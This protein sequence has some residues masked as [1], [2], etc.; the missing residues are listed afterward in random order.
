MLD[1]SKIQESKYLFNEA[2]IGNYIKKEKKFF[3]YHL[4]K[5]NEIISY[6]YNP[7]KVFGPLIPNSE[8]LLSKKNTGLPYTWEAV[9]I[10]DNWIGI[11]TF[12]PNKLVKQMLENGLIPGETFQQEKLIK[13]LKYKPDFSNERY[14]IEVKH[15]H[16]VKDNIGYFPEK[17]TKRG[18]CQL[19]AIFQL[20]K[21]GQQVILIY[22]MQ[23]NMTDTFSISKDR[24][25]VYYNKVLEAKKIGVKSFAFNCYVNKEGVFI[26]SLMNF[27]L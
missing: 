5:N 26:K 9:K 18:S 1:L 3:S 6:C 8:S 14:I 27:I 21:N 12:T 15:S 22:I 25:P 19:E 2:I 20:Q 24:D 17:I 23:N 10:Q 7:Q 4:F 16:W 13:E 11:N